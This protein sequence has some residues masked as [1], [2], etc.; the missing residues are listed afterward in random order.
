[1]AVDSNDAPLRATTEDPH[2]DDDGVVG[3]E[4]GATAPESVEATL[5]GQRVGRFVPIACIGK[6]GMGVVWSAYDPQLDRKVA[7]KLIV[8]D[9]GRRGSSGGERAATRMLREARALAKLN[10]PNVVAVYDVGTHDDG[11]Y[12]AMEFVEG[13]PLDR[14]L[15]VARPWR[16]VLGLFVA[17]ARGLAAAHAAGL[18]H[19]DFKPSNVVVTPGGRVVVLDFGLARAPVVLSDPS[20]MPLVGD[21]QATEGGALLGTPAYMSPEQWRGLAVDARSDQFNFCVGLWEALCRAHPF[22]RTSTLTLADSVTSGRVREFPPDV[23]VPSRIVAAVRRGLAKDPALRWPSMDALIAALESGE[24]RRWPVLAGAGA[25]AIA[26]VTWVALSSAHAPEDPCASTGERTATVWNDARRDAARTAFAATDRAFAE[27]AWLRVETAIEAYVRAWQGAATDACHAVQRGTVAAEQA[28]LQSACLGEALHRV[29]ALVQRLSHAGVQGV[30]RATDAVAE[31]PALD[32][33]ADFARLGAARPA[34]DDAADAE[35]RRRLVELDAALDVF[36]DEAVAELSPRIEAAAARIDADDGAID[37]GIG[38]EALAA[39]ARLS[40]RRG[41][42]PGALAQLDRAAALAMSSGRDEVFSD[43]ALALAVDLVLAEGS[44]DAAEAWWKVASA[45]VERARGSVVRRVEAKRVGTMIATTR[46]EL[47]QARALADEAEAL[48]RAAMGNTHVL[49]LRTAAESARVAMLQGDYLAALA[50]YDELVAAARETYGAKHPE[51][52]DMTTM[53]ITAAIEA[54]RR[55]GL[56][57]HAREV[58]D[59]LDPDD[60]SFIWAQLNLGSALALEG[61]W[62]EADAEFVKVHALLTA[63]DGAEYRASGVTCERGRYALLAGRPGVAWANAQ[64]C[65][66]ELRAWA[67]GDVHGHDALALASGLVDVVTIAA[68]TDH[69]DDALRLLAELDAAFA[70]GEGD[71][72]TPAVAKLAGVQLAIAADD[73]AAAEAQARDVLAWFESR[74]R[75][76][77]R[78]C[79]DALALAIDTARWAGDAALAKARADIGAGLLAQ[80]PDAHPGSRRRLLAAMATIG[81]RRD[82]AL[83]EVARLTPLAPVDPELELR[84]R[85]EAVRTGTADASAMAAIRDEAR[86]WSPWLRQVVR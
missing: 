80:L 10:D 62:D 60:P 20:A 86:R 24:R 76:N 44:T 13:V 15:A 11:L 37:P 12:I 43:V 33:C 67:E 46:H 58:F 79:L 47:V 69:R 54:G 4:R 66:A 59:G 48:A 68:H 7:L 65:E 72:D 36:D 73:L 53:R 30:T 22:D 40:W 70:R 75:T 39:L 3:R 78:T 25:T 23:G 64:Q 55:E 1:V 61:F 17:A 42:V 71:D 51:T 5:L 32:G 56:A 77:K 29:D 49:T 82:A 21:P 27:D 16:E 8:D 41:D 34:S 28:A 74:G 84:L 85:F 63:H 50:K 38:A 9:R 14:H 57:R 18:V 31:L 35:V 19:R 81:E 83:A 52:T 45:A 2:A 26:A 6:G